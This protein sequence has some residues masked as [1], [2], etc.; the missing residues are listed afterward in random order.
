MGSGGALLLLNKVKE[1]L[2]SLKAS[3]RVM[4]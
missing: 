2:T 3:L 1:N 4:L